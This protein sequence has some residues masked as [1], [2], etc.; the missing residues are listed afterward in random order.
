MWC[1]AA[2]GAAEGVSE[3]IKAV[4]GEGA[5]GDLAME[6]EKEE[7][8]YTAFYKGG[9]SG[10]GRGLRT[11]LAAVL[12]GLRRQEDSWVFEEPVTESIAP[13]YHEQI[14]VPMDYSTVESRLE[15][16]HYS[17]RLEV[18]ERCVMA[19]SSKPLVCSLRRT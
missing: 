7:F 6:D 19:D 18:G 12:S 16:K 17:T 11:Y 2:L 15:K 5:L 9:L 14:S 1:R 10:C 8:L 3:V 13:G 4:E